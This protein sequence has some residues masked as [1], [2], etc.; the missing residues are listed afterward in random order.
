VVPKGGTYDSKVVIDSGNAIPETNEADNTL[1]QTVTVVPQSAD[2]TVSL[3][4]LHALNNMEFSSCVPVV[5]NPYDCGSGEWGVVFLVFDPTQSCDVNVE[6]G[7]SGDDFELKLPSV[8]CGYN[9]NNHDV[10]DNSDLT[11]HFPMN[12]TVHLVEQ[13]PLVAGVGA[14]E[15]DFAIPDIPGFSTFIKSRSDY[16]S[17][18][19]LVSTPGQS[20]AR[21]SG[22]PDVGQV[23]PVD[24]GHCF[25]AYW[26][27]STAN[28]VGPSNSVMMH[29]TL[30]TN[31]L[32]AADDTTDPG[33]GSYTQA[34][35]V[36]QINDAYSQI[37]AAAIAAAQQSGSAANVHISMH[38]S[39][40]K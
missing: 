17:Q 27:V 31:A 26:G 29:N 9:N 39:T 30:K 35:E 21:V 4:H 5:G 22:F 23:T 8:Y 32:N 15:E 40:V 10:D 1:T 2:V 18:S 28:V 34:Q 7:D 6:L 14:V 24:D 20:C 13:T 36:A 37:Q 12:H 16:L 3:D 11:D 38:S 33:D 25:D 19:G